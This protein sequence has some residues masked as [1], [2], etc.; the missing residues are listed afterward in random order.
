MKNLMLVSITVFCLAL[1]ALSSSTTADEI[2]AGEYITN[3]LMLGPILDAGNALES[4][5]V[6][7][8]KDVG[9]EANVRPSEGDVFEAKKLTWKVQKLASNGSIEKLP[10]FNVDFATVYMAIYLKF[11][12]AE[13]VD[14][15][16]GSDD[17]I[18]VWLNGK[19]VWKN[20]VVRYWIADVDKI[21]VDV[22]AGWNFLLVKIGESEGGWVAS[23]KFPNTPILDY[24]FNKRAQRELIA[25]TGEEMFNPGEKVI[26]DI[27]VNSA[28]N[29]RK[30]QFDLKFS[31]DVLRVISVDE[32]QFL[33]KQGADKTKWQPK[34][35]ISFVD[36]FKKTELPD[37]PTDGQILTLP[38]DENKPLLSY[39]EIENISCE[40]IAET[41]VSGDGVLARITFEA[42]KEGESSLDF[43]NVK[44]LAPGDEK[45]ELSI[46]NGSV[47][48]IPHGSI[49]GVVLDAANGVPISDAMVEVLKDGALAAPAVYSDDDGKYTIDGI[50][51]G[52][53][54]VIASKE[55]Y[56]PNSVSH[57][58]VKQGKG[59][60]DVNFKIK[61]V[62]PI[63][64]GEE[65]RDFRLTSIEG[66]TVRLSQ[67]RDNNI[68]LV[69]N[70]NPY[71]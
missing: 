9:G 39:G 60:P 33:N 21:K 10:G 12:R 40:R 71:T 52:T 2:R 26:V 62:T 24:S 27:A 36:L 35:Q 45:V 64:A 22:K 19:S 50:P 13:K 66:E 29:L 47:S 15:W 51:I 4:I 48:V 42:L 61:Q 1:M 18:A 31:Q 17:S 59:M 20:P 30:F 57:A 16:L 7:V 8:L 25:L 32:G 28:E 43:Q 34:L 63:R 5:D 65:A 49:S 6:D 70:G 69:S 46:I 67:F 41:G 53:V 44:L 14:L 37:Q 11:A 38:Y 56:I 55:K 23:V 58:D 68:V 54:E 3:W